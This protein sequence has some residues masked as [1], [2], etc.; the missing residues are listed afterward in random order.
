MINSKLP[1]FFLLLFLFL[2]YLYLLP[3][4]DSTP[5]VEEDIRFVKEII[6]NMAAIREA[7]SEV[8]GFIHM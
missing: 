5:E 3:E 7:N 2:F 8:G 4:R 1:L 6:S